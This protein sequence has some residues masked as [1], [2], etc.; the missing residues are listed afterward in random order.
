[1]PVKPPRWYF[2]LRSPYSWL[3]CRELTEN[4]PDVADAVEWRPYWEPGPATEP[5][6]AAEGVTL[7]YVP[8]SKEKHLYILQDV[9]RLAADRG[10]TVAW[11]IDAAPDWDVSHLA[12]FLAEDQGRGREYVALV[13]EA[14]WARGLDISDPAVI[15]A[16][17]KELGLDGDAL[18][19]AAGDPR[20][21]ARGLEA[22]R[23][24]GRDGVFGVPFFIH[25]HDKFWGTDRLD[26]FVATVR[27][28]HRPAPAAGARTAE[29]PRNAALPAPD[30]GERGGDTGHAGGCG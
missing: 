22:L 24:V 23:Q 28:A 11:P 17:G 5:L 19:A 10:L 26:R 25:R 21:L 4:A 14:R 27:A 18:A 1:M 3:A 2:S 30:E 15:A 12:W 8:M 29:P 7:P 13:G 9:K 6:L 16:V 20:L